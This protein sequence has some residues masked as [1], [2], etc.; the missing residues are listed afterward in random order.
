ME[1]LIEV[2]AM[3]GFGEYVW[4]SYLLALLVLGGLVLLSRRALRRATHRLNLLKGV[5]QNEA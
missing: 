4:P 1:K 5:P 3:G 2:L